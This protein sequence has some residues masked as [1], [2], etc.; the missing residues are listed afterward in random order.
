MDPVRLG[1][2]GCG[3][4]GQQHVMQA[5]RWPGATVVAVADLRE[6]VAR[7]TASTFGVEQIC[8]SADDLIANPDVEGV[9]LAL[10]ANARKALA[11]RAFAEGKHVLTEKPVA[12]NA[13]EVNELI[14][15][16]GDLIAGC[17]SSRMRFLS[18]A[19]AASE[20]LA[21]G[22]LGRLRVIRCRAIKPAGPPPEAPPPAWRLSRTL[23]G[24]G[25]LMNWGPYDLDY[26]L[27]LTS[28]TLRPRSVL[29]QTWAV[30]NVYANYVAPVSD[31]ETHIAALVRFDDGAVLIYER[32]EHVAAQGDEAWQIT[33][34]KGSLRLQMTP[35]EGKTIWQDVADP[36]QGVVT[37]AIWHGD[38]DYGMTHGG[39]VKDFASA[40]REGRQ[41]LTSLEHALLVQG[42]TDAIYAS[43]GRGEVV[44]L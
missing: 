21:R 20:V 36:E 10:P 7:K 16:R 4:I 30:P 31:A 28:D 41:P 13:G 33:G 43:A 6:E 22:V 2:I 11:L 8:A 29:A 12:L 38:E 39:V 34:E 5:T 26:L 15:A 42:L 44:A 35:G 23:N 3:T 32:G 17:C 40:I 27:A 9:I 24:G 19:Q 1:I 14:A 37:T 25:V 18:S